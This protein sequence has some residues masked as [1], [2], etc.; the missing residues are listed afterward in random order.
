MAC[1]PSLSR[2]PV[3]SGLY[4]GEAI[5]A[6]KV[7]PQSLRTHIQVT[8]AESMCTHHVWAGE[9]A[10]GWAGTAQSHPFHPCRP[11]DSG[12]GERSSQ[13]IRE[14]GPAT[15]NRTGVGHQPSSWAPIPHDNAGSPHAS[16]SCHQATMLN[17]IPTK[18][19]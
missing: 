8:A 13:R 16:I 1:F 10:D 17:L 5:F 11:L 2:S 9:W 3:L 14:R 6:F 18:C 4:C 7:T 12:V 19:L 15:G